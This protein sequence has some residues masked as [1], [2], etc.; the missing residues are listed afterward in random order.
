MNDEL[1]YI[2]TYLKE[3]RG[4]DFSGCRGAMVARRVKH[5]FAP[6]A[7]GDIGEYI[8]YLKETPGE[9]D[10][11]INALTINVSRFFRDP[12]TFEYIAER[13]LPTLVYEKQKGADSALRLWSAGCS[14][15]E[16]PYSVAI[17]IR[18]FADREG[19]TCDVAIFATDI[20]SRILAKAQEACYPPESVAAVK[21]GL[22][23]KYFEQMGARFQLVPSIRQMV[24]FSAYDLLHKRSYCPP[25]SI[26]G[27]FDLVLCRNV[28]IYF[29][30]DWQG[31]IFD[32][33]HR[34]LAKGGFLVLGEAEMPPA[35]FRHRF[36]RS[37]DCCHVYRKL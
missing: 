12:L 7:C 32:K 37:S 33:L 25:E 21:Y 31:L 17:L 19:L 34:S 24:L 35:A 1:T 15:G 22:L 36:I 27:G 29:N 26:F 2:L 11:L 8:R 23:T 6:T 9:I 10:H 5:R 18:E 13:L 16:E 20:D 30:A 14:M 4:F 28:L 3:T